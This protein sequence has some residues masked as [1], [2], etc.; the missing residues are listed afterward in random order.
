MLSLKRYLSIFFLLS[1][2]LCDSGLNTTYYP[3]EMRAIPYN[4]SELIISEQSCVSLKIGYGFFER[5]FK[6]IGR[7]SVK[8]F[9]KDN[10]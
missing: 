8:K 7:Q 2:V 9:N 1:T 5:I 10:S 4:V 3:E 6:E